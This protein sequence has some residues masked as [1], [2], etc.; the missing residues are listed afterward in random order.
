MNNSEMRTPYYYLMQGISHIT[1][2][3]KLRK[4]I[5]Y[6]SYLG[7][8]NHL[9]QHLQTCKNY[10]Q[11]IADYKAHKQNRKAK[12]AVYSCFTGDYDVPVKLKCLNPDFDYI[13][14]VDNPELYNPA[15]YPWEFRRNEFQELDVVRNARH[16]KILAHKVLPE[17]EETVWIDSN[18][19]ILSPLLY[20]DIQKTRD[21]GIKFA[22][23]AH[24]HRDCSYAEAQM[25]LEMHRDNPELINAECDYLK[26][27]GFPEHYGLFETNV[28]YRRRDALVEKVCED[29]MEMLVRFSRR[30]QLAL[31]FAVWKNEAPK[32]VALNPISYRNLIGDVLVSKHFKKRKKA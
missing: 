27:K 8:F 14:F 13:M 19:D 5:Y 25:C 23:S 17:Y 24:P 20:Q 26:S 6:L 12:L 32:P 7:S 18:I 1:P 15:D 28:M 21:A 22:I 29:W 31:M 10:R 2:F 16:N 30:D 3:R 11:I 4:Q 9:W